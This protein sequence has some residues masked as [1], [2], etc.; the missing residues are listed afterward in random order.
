MVA[1]NIFQEFVLR[2][3][4]D[5]DGSCNA[6]CITFTSTSKKLCHQIQHLLLRQNIVS[7]ISVSIRKGKTGEINGRT[8]NFNSDLYNVRITDALSYNNLASLLRIDHRKT[9]SKFHKPKYRFIDGRLYSKIRSIERCE[10]KTVVNIT[11][12]EDSSFLAE[13]VNTHNCDALA[14]ACGLASESMYTG[15]PQSGLVNMPQMPSLGS[16]SQWKIGNASISD[17]QWRLWNR[18]FGI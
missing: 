13:S 14:G 18:K 15:Y 5:G 10:L 7:S 8:I 17:Q 1:P 4:F 3:I 2:G 9:Q 11:V 12:D 16:N 6:K